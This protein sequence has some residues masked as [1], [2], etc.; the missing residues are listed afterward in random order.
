MK[1]QIPSIK[2]WGEYVPEMIATKSVPDEVPWGSYPSLAGKVE[3]NASQTYYTLVHSFTPASLSGVIFLSGPTMVEQDQGANFGEQLSALANCFKTHFGGEEFP[4]VYSVPGKDL[5]P[6][7]TKPAAIEG[8][9]K[10]VEVGAWDDT[11]VLLKATDAV[12]E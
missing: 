12:V 7:I 4:F 10:A 5:A 1:K 3:T 2:L 8:S 11:E 9:S 6:K